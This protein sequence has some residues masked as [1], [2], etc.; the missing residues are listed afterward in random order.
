MTTT[1]DELVKVGDLARRTGLTVRTLHHYDQVGLLRPSG[2]TVGGHRL[3]TDADISR[4]Y[5]IIALKSLGLPLDHVADVLA[6]ESDDPRD[7]LRQQ[8][9]QVELQMRAAERLRTRLLTVL[10]ALDRQLEPS[11]ADFLALIEGTHL[12]EQR[13]DAHYSAMQVE[14]LAARRAQLGQDKVA[15]LEAEWAELA[16]RAQLE[17]DRRTDPADPVVQQ[18][19][20]RWKDVLH[21]F[22]GGDPALDGALRRI[23]QHHGTTIHATYG[24][25]SPELIDFILQAWRVGT[26]GD[27]RPAG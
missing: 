5:Q 27:A 23:W 10:A 19:A 26:S 24:G 11:A 22:T 13:I 21:A 4:L 16:V 2:R 7:V 3:Y 12:T 6:Q 18:I 1:P 20:D 14:Q 8:V 9:R 25:P 15:E 17:L